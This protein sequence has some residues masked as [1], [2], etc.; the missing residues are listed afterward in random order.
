MATNSQPP[1]RN[2]SGNATDQPFGP[3]ADCGNGNPAFYHQ[4][5]DDF[6][7]SFGTPATPTGLWVVTPTPGTSA[8]HLAGD[9]GLALLTTGAGAGSEA[10]IQLPAASFT[11]TAPQKMF[12]ETRMQL[13]TLT[14]NAWVT[15]LTNTN[16]TPFAGGITDGIYFSKAVGTT[17]IN[18]IVVHGSTVSATVPIPA[19]AITTY[20]AATNFD[21]AWYL[22][23]HGDIRVYAN[24]QLV[25]W[26]PQS[27]TGV[28]SPP[29]AGLGPCAR[30]TAP[31]LPTANLNVTAA[32]YNGVTAV[33]TTMT[34][35]FICVSKER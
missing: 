11:A 34:V 1:V 17:T 8:V 27:G 6:D 4:F 9:G 26:I 30:A 3:F 13:A 33:A 12:F 29:T 16:T 23:R 21:L 5:F 7:E 32:V 18:L 20:A 10:E 2:P 25:G 22:D 15:G 19:G 35:D 24:N 28:T 31:V 14:T